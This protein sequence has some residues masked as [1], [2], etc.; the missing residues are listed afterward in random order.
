MYIV[1]W[2][3]DSLYM[4]QNEKGTRLVSYWEYVKLR[5]AELILDNKAEL[6]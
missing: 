6:P 1:K 4:L 2:A 3:E 5:D